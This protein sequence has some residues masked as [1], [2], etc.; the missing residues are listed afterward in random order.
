MS[1]KKSVLLLLVFAVFVGGYY[2]L[3]KPL[4]GDKDGG[5]SKTDD[6]S[7]IDNEFWYAGSFEDNREL[8][9]ITNEGGIV[10]LKKTD[11]GEDVYLLSKP[12]H[13]GKKQIVSIKR[14]L[15][16]K[17]GKDYFS[18]GIVLFQTQSKRRLINTED[19]LPYGSALFLVEYVYNPN[20]YGK[21][22]GTK[23][24]RLLAPDYNENQNYELLDGIFNKWYEEEISYNSYTGELTYTENTHSA[25]IKVPP[26]TDDHIRIWM[27]AY[28][29]DKT[30]QIE[31]DSIDIEVKNI[32]DSELDNAK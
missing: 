10:T 26:I 24:I 20:G 16:I 23:N 4:M 11:A 7:L 25:S 8:R 19:K 27:H 17:P 5:F 31:V 3:I 9:S 29:N 13:V 28:G 14:R 1:N 2:F 22:P 30:Q 18:G 21:R 12:I 15:R 6:F 32:E